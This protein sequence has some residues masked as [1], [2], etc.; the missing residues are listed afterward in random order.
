MQRWLSHPPVKRWY[1]DPSE[2][3]EMVRDFY[4]PSIAGIKPVQPFIFSFDD[5]PAGYIQSY[6]PKDWPDY[7]GKQDLPEGAAGI[8]V[9]I[10]EDDFRHRSFG[11][12]V[13]NAF[14][15]EFLAPDPSITEIIIDPDPANLAAIRAY[16]KAGFARIREI[17]PPDNIEPALLMTRSVRC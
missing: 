12:L 2:T 8:D 4:A 11:P 10:G 6:R 14:I 17:G 15:D 9:F 3:V 1:D 7:W 5:R 13:I 16:E